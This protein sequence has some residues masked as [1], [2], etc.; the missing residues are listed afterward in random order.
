MYVCGEKL[1]KGRPDREIVQGVLDHF[2][3]DN[4]INFE[5]RYLDDLLNR[6]RQ[7]LFKLMLFLGSNP[8]I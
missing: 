7:T 3:I 4:E 6:F 5:E 1:I 2:D 8:R